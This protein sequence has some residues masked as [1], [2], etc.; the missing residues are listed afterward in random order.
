MYS[1]LIKGTAL[2]FLILLASCV[3]RVDFDVELRSNFP[4]VIEGHISN[5]S[6]PYVVRVSQAFDIDSK[7]NTKV[8]AL[9]KQVELIDDA[10]NREVFQQVDKGLYMTDPNGMKG[11][12]GRAYYLRVELLNGAMFESQPDTLHKPGKLDNLFYQYGA[13]GT[14]DVNGTTNYEFDFYFDGSTGQASNPYFMW[15]FIATFKVNTQPELDP[16]PAEP[17]TTNLDCVGCNVCNLAWKCSGLRNKGTAV[18]PIFVRLFP[19]TCCECWYNIFNESPILAD[20]QFLRAGKFIN[21]KAGSVPVHEWIFQHKVYVDVSQMS[22][23]E[24][25]FN[26]FNSIKEQKD[27][28]NSLFQPITGKVKT[29]FRQVSG[30]TTTVDGIFYAAGIDAKT[31][32][33][34][35]E[36]VPPG[37]FIFSTEDPPPPIAKNCRYLFPNSTNI[38]PAFWQD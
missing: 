4:F 11:E 5:Q 9:V 1:R 10:G 38:K 14:N 17:C 26:Y 12:V 13:K 16:K 18:D 25:S 24:R 32:I 3:E 30:P 31:I 36:D 33:L 2:F 8:P 34:T 28:V 29:T 6:G 20:P 7:I 23:S 15:K 21:I 27:A 35:K 22:L 37:T 19:C